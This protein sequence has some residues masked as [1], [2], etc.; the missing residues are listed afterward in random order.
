MPPNQ[1]DVYM[2]MPDL[3]ACCAC[4]RGDVLVRNIMMLDLRA[5]VPGT[6]W[7]CA[8]CGVPLDG[9]LSVL[10]DACVATQQ[11]SRFVVLGSL[12]D[13]KRVAIEE[14][15]E[16]FGHNMKRHPE[17]ADARRARQAHLN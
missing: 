9:A 17:V 6:G 11:P 3:G 14:V 2:D 12:T 5:P 10:C 8:Q 4:G 1:Y 16:H 13:G 15:T 7:G